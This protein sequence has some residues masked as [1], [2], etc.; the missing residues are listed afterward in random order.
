MGFIDVQDEIL[1]YVVL[2]VAPDFSGFVTDY[3]TWP[4]V[5]ASYFR[6]SQA[7]TWALLTRRFFEAHPG[8]KGRSSRGKAPFEAKVYFALEQLVSRL[9]SQRFIKVDGHQT[10]VSIKKLG[11]DTRWGQAS[12]TIKRFCRESRFRESLVPYFGH[13]VSPARK[14]FEEYTR[15]PGWLFEDQVC[16]EVK[17]VKWI[18]RPGADGTYYMLADVNR[19]KDFL[20]ARLASPPGTPG[21]FVLFDAPPEQHRLFADHVCESEYPEP[22]TA[23]GLTKNIWKPRD[24]R[25]DNDYLD[26][27]VG[28]CALAGF[29]GAALRSTPARRHG[30]P[31]RKRK[32]ITER[33]KRGQK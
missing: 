8:Q 26:C 20:F 25:P 9:L 16:P 6:K 23:R 24:G 4:E 32:P 14:Q 30:T 7:Q 21:S 11:I 33:W 29:C 19:L 2:A 3:G 18:Y 10:E 12:D 13:S 27:L 22:V 15:T 17:E 28:C 1:F 5:S 31:G